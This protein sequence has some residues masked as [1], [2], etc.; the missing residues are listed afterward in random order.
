[1]IEISCPAERQN[2]RFARSILTFFC[3]ARSRGLVKLGQVALDGTKV[4]ANASK[5]K[6]TSYDRM[7]E[8]ELRLKREVRAWFDTAKS[9][10]EA[11]AGRRSRYR[12]RKTLPEP[13][14]GQ[15]KQGRG[16]R[17]FL[18]RGLAKVQGEWSLICNYD[19]LGAR[20]QTTEHP[21]KVS[22]EYG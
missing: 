9:T 18:L 7:R 21:S 20:S 13:V 3:M 17:Q 14:F 16:F 8:T 10:D 2:H 12:L 19:L 6:A 11:R 4:K 1:M 5:H 22:P 15:V